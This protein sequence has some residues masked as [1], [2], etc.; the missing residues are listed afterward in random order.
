[1]FNISH[2]NS[3]ALFLF[4]SIVPMAHGQ[5]SNPDRPL[6]GAIRW[7]GWAGNNGPVGLTGEKELGPE[8][9]HYRV[10]FFGQVISSSQVAINGASQAVVDQE[11]A[12][13]RT[14]LDYWAFVTYDANSELTLPL[15]YYLSSSHKQDM[16][17][18]MLTEENRWAGQNHMWAI[19]RVVPLMK[20]ATYL[21]VLGGRPLFYLGFIVDQDVA[22]NWGGMAGFRKAVDDFRAAARAAG[23]GNPYIVIMDFDPVRAHSLSQQLGGDAISAYAQQMDHLAPGAAYLSLASYAESSWDQ[24]RATGSQVIPIVM[25]GWDRRPRVENPAYWESAQQPGVGIQYFYQAP[26]PSELAG[27]LANAFNWI[28]G[29][30]NSDEANAVLIYAWNENAEG[31]WLVPTLSEGTARLDALHGILTSVAPPLAAVT[32]LAPSSATAGRAGFTLTVTGT[33]FLSGATVQWNGAP[34][35]TTFSSATQLTAAV[36]ASLIATAGSASITVSNPGGMA[37]KAVS[38]TINPPGIS[39][40][41][42]G[43]VNGASHAGGAVSPGEIV[44]ISGSGFGTGAQA[45]FDGV[46]APLLSAQSGQVTAVVPY[47]VSGNPSTQLQ[48]SYQGQS[49]IA[50]AVPVAA[51][52]PG[53]FTVDGSGNGQ[54]LIANEDG[55]ANAP[56]NAASV[57]TTV[58]VYA[59]GEGQTIPVGVDGKLG[60]PAT[61]P[62]PILPVTATVGGLDAPVG[63]ASGISGMTAGYLQVSVQ[64]P[65]DVMVGD[66]VPIVLN[67]GGITSQANVTLALQ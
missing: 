49:S 9:W 61:P 41:A 26:K 21:K 58:V 43:V 23:V 2:A 60:D 1:M 46:T 37:S 44:T 38:F 29:H 48:V 6:V 47:E 63:A 56:G 39:I 57:G 27:H 33:G 24:Y 64:I 45:Q 20:E 53:I 35:A 42:S 22:Q 14:G 16:R 8:H 13:A 3:W 50:V 62:V 12:Y 10:P 32:S 19:S 25:S 30:P 66:S 28:N 7:D 52:A 55:S 40:S 34:L 18:C 67:I 31:G 17:F 36:P 54:G 65:P 15:Q 11:I 59:T 4:G 5:T 51:A